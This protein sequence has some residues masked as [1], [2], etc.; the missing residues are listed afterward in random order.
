MGQAEG[1][2]PS[3]CGSVEAMA[4]EGDPSGIGT[5][6]PGDASKVEVLPAPL[7]PSKATI[8]PSPM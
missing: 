7:G 4:G 1:D 2:R 8:S 6:E 3:R 5:D